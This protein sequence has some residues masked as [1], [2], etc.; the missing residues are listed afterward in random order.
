[1]GGLGHDAL[2]EGARCFDKLRIVQQGERL[3][4]R[5]RA[6]APDDAILARG[7]VEQEH[8]GRRALSLPVDVE[9]ATVRGRTGVGHIFL[10]IIVRDRLP[11]SGRLPGFHAVSALFFHQQPAQEQSRVAHCFGIHAET[12][13]SRQ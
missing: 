12:R 3:Q 7:S 11:K 2:G 1:M 10:R 4:G 8:V 6:R 13:R 9:A 5:V